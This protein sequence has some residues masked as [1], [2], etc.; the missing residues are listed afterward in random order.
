SGEVAPDPGV[1]EPV[2]RV[3]GGVSVA[4]LDQTWHGLTPGVGL[5]AQFE[6]RFG[7]GANAVLGRAGFTQDDWGK[8][9]EVL[10]G[11]ERARAGLALVSA[12][13]A[14]LLLLDEPTNHLDVEALD[15]LEDAIHAYAGAVVIVTH[16]RRFAREV[17]N[18]LWMVED[19][20]LREP[21]GWGSREYRD[22]AATLMGDPPPLP[23]PPTPRQRLVPIE[24]QLRDIRALLDQPGKLTGRE[25]ARLRSQAHAL[26]EHL[27]GLYAAAF[28]APQ[29]DLQVREPGLTVRAQRFGEHGGMVWAARDDTCPHLAWDGV[30]LRWN[31]DP[32]PW[33]GATLTGGALRILFEHWNVGRVQLGEDG[34]QV[35]RRTWF[36]RTGVIR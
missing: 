19:G 12:L 20:T 3:G 1:P 24:N 31:G 26:Q 36:E 16:D 25:E 34:P 14:D 2:L 33:Y 15:A 21:V 23:P 4:S 7:R 18:R 32:P 17:A 29:Y 30:T 35:T 8:T 13:R 11:G 27:Y 5:Q 22:P 9:P 10:S 28:D 6:R